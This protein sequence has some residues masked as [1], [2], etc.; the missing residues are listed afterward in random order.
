VR[1]QTA[2]EMHIA[3]ETVQLADDDRTAK[4]SRSLDGGPLSQNKV[5]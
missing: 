1:H 2:D 3:T 4:L 5:K